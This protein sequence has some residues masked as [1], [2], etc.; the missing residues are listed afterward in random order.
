M[1]RAASA[2]CFLMAGGLLG[3]QAPAASPAVAPTPVAWSALT[4]RIRPSAPPFPGMARIAGV[5]GRVAVRAFLDRNGTVVRAEATEGPAMLRPAA[6]AWCR[7]W[8]FAPVEVDG[9][10]VEAVSQIT[11]AFR[12]KD[13]A[14]A[15]EAPTGALLEVEQGPAGGIPPAELEAVRAEAQ[16]WL[17]RLGL[18]LAE[19]GHADPAHTLAVKVTVQLR[20]AWDRA[21]VYLVQARACL[22]RDRELAFDTP[23]SQGLACV[24]THMVGLP[25]GRDTV[26]G[27]KGIVDQA[28]RG[29]SE[30]RGI[31]E[32]LE[33][34]K[35]A[36]STGAPGVP[37]KAGLRDFDFSQIRVRYQPPAP[38]YPPEAKSRRIQGTVV[39]ELVVG[40]DG[41][42]IRAEAIQ[43]PVELAE[44]AIGFAL[45]WKFAPAL[46]NGVPMYARFKL[47]MPFRL[48]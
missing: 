41:T 16:A 47:T 18:A 7:Q 28:L 42:P 31:P 3:A 29:L 2:V 23:Q 5:Q 20:Y 26:A 48:R 25:D 11:L 15:R 19:A 32:F 27:V 14:E 39:V 22:L 44:T 38:P 30:P 9:K 33:K 37:G 8:T 40:P 46:L 12:L 4:P 17:G 13:V 43:G 21:P 24:S 35:A 36:A 10:P 45:R 34:A 1:Q 6:E